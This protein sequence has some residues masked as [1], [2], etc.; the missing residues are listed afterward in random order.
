MQE[1][2][3]DTEHSETF[4]EYT[5][6]GHSDKGDR[7][8]GFQQ[9]NFLV[10]QH[11]EGAFKF[12]T[13]QASIEDAIGVSKIQNIPTGKGSEKLPLLKFSTLRALLLLDFWNPIYSWQRGV[14][15]QYVPETIIL[16]QGTNGSTFDFEDRF[17]E[18]IRGSSRSKE[19]GTPEQRFLELRTQFAA[20]GDDGKKLFDST[21]K[22]YCD[23]GWPGS[24]SPE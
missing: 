7:G 21:I 13:L 19:K 10:T 8:V 11:G 9:A 22:K 15:M 4:P 3:P 2:P 12:T 18:S 14:L 24:I 16:V 17:I 20:S 23:V 1:V 6:G 5:I